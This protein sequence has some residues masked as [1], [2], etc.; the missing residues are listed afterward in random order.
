[1]RL[2]PSA[3]HGSE[4][5]FL[6]RFLFLF[7]CIRVVCACVC[8]AVVTHACALRPEE[9]IWVFSCPFLPYAL[10]QGLS[11][12]SELARVFVFVY[13]FSARTVAGQSQ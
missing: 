7:V 4:M 12:N 9:G 5:L 2:Q 6:F 8:T 11:L 3:L 1:M 13:L 10:R